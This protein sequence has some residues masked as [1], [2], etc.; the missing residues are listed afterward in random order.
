MNFASD[1][2]AGPSRAVAEALE[3]A[4]AG[5]APA[6]GADEWTRRA[7]ERFA[8]LFEREVRVFFVATGTAANALSLAT[9]S[10]P[11]GV[12]LAHAESHAAD[13]EA[14]AVEFASGMRLARIAGPLGRITPEALEATLKRYGSVMA[15]RAVALTLSQAT[16]LGT[17]YSPGEIA[18]L[19]AIAHEAKLVV[20]MDGARFANAVVGLGAGPADVTWRAG[21]DI[22]SFGGTKNGCW[23]AEAI[24]V[25][26][27]RL[28]A[29]LPFA[30]KR[31]GHVLSKARFVAAQFLAYLEGGH[32]LDNAVHANA[33]AQR[34]G[35]GLPPGGPVRLAWASEAN[36]VFLIWPRALGARL[37]G[38]GARFHEWQTEALPEG[39]WVGADEQLVRL[40]TSFATR[41]EEVGRLLDALGEG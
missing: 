19:A 24:V 27:Q 26:D 15:G 1:N 33:M 41:P 39:V 4:R 34:I 29:D 3:A 28:A 20:H 11:G 25:F 23:C 30:L 6:Y 5:S 21:V 36:E 2:W 8:E 13:S 35:E 12:I 16:E 38:R 37:A 14:G 31:A 7:E 9:A 17:V 10:T 32:W 22:L 18:A 40:V